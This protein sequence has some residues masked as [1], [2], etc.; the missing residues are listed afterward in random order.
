MMKKA[1]APGATFSSDKGN[2]LIFWVAVFSKARGGSLRGGYGRNPES[3][4]FAWAFSSFNISEALAAAFPA[5]SP[6]AFAALPSASA[7]E[8]AASSAAAMSVRAFSFNTT[9]ATISPF[10][11]A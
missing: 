2:V 10:S 7:A 3:R 11:P 6:I 9:R 4:L 8:P 1:S 5:A